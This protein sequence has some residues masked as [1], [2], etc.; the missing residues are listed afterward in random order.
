MDIAVIGSNNVDLI[1][2]IE[3]MPKKG[4]TLEALNFEMGNGGKGA[5][6]AVAAAKLGSEV[7]MVTKVGDDMFAER[8]IANFESHGIDTEFTKKVP[9]T[10]SGV[11][12]IFVDPNSDNRILIIKGANDHLA[13]K[14]VDAAAD[15]LTK[16]KLIVLQLEVPLET[17]Y[18]AIAFGKQHGIPVIFNPAPAVKNLDFHYVTMC[19]YVIPNETELE[20]ITEMPVGTEEEIR[21]AAR[22]LLNK[23]VRNVIVTLGR[24]GVLWVTPDDAHLFEAYTVD[25]VDTTGAGDAFIGCFAQSIVQTN[26]VAQSIIRAQGFAALSVMKN[27]TQISYPD[28]KKLA[29]FL[30]E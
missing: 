13:P 4:E 23:G 6:Q 8:T 19:D 26:D 17:V 22:M 12:P 10:T 1:T 29:A 3:K 30:A 16:C 21:H 11:A 7:M 5:N 24:R 15:K 27:G 2:Y 14:D 9:G 28:E 18:Y 25:A 20:L